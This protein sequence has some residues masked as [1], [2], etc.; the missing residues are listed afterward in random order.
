LPESEETVNPHFALPLVTAF[1]AATTGAAYAC[2]A[3]KITGK[4]EKGLKAD[5]VVVDM[6]WS[7][8]RLLQAAVD[9]TW[10]EGRKVFNIKR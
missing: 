6:E 3:D 8:E 1:T 5:F 10:F 7:K 9:E 2:F 4:L